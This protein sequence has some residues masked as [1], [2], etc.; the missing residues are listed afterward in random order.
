MECFVTEYVDID[1]KF[2]RVLDVNDTDQSRQGLEEKMQT[3][4]KKLQEAESNLQ[5]F[6][7]ILQPNDFMVSLHV[8][9]AFFH[10]SIG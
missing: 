3:V 9:N 8:E 7:S 6:P 1:R 5:K 10:V 2:T 4:E